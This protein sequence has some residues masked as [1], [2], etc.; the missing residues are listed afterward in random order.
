MQQKKLLHSSIQ[1]S[2][3]RLDETPNFRTFRTLPYSAVF[4]FRFNET[5][6]NGSCKKI[7]L[8]IH[9]YSS[10]HFFGVSPKRNTYFPYFSVL[11]RTLPYFSVLCRFCVSP[12]RND[13]KSKLMTNWL[14]YSSVLFRTL[15]NVSSKRNAR[16]TPS[17]RL[18]FKIIKEAPGGV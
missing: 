14:P 18:A 6:R 13:K 17:P 7:A 11:F 2:A 8:R 4:A 3:F 10:V 16:S 15:F 9:P 12:Q 1:F 5:I